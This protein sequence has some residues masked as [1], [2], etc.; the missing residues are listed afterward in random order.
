LSDLADRHASRLSGGEVQR[1][2]LARGLV[3]ETPIL[4]LDEPT[5][6]LDDSF[7]P[8][9]LEMLRKANQRRQVTVLAATHDLHFAAA[10]AHRVFH[11]EA[12]KM[13]NPEMTDRTTGW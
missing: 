8:L 4:L 10:L 6:F 12:G 11:L 3:L 1:V 2:V 5:S 9:L 13:V 7:R